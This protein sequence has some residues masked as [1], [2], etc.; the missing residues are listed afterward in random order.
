MALVKALRTLGRAR[1]YKPSEVRIL[2]G[3]SVF[4][5]SVPV[6]AHR[7]GVV[8]IGGAKNGQVVKALAARAA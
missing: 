7:I 6:G 4:H 1:R 3:A 5:Q 8:S 2:S